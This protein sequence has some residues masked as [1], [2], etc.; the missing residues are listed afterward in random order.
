M[1][2]IYVILLW[3]FF[4]L[5]PAEGIGGDKQLKPENDPLLKA[6]QI[7]IKRAKEGL[8]LPEQPTPYFISFWIQ[9]RATASVS[10]KYGAI[11]H[12]HPDFHPYRTAGV[13]VRVGD[14]KLDNTNLPFSTRFSPESIEDMLGEGD[15][16]LSQV[17]IEGDGASLR[18]TLWLMSDTA[19]KG[20]VGDYQK[21]KVLQ[22][23]SVDNDKEQKPDDFS[24]HAPIVF[25]GPI[26]EISFDQEMWKDIVRK[27]TSHL[28]S[29]K[30]IMEPYMEVRADIIV[31]YYVNTEGAI[32][33]TSEVFYTVDIHAWTRAVD[34]AK[35]D[36]FRYFFVRD[37]KELQDTKNFIA[38]AES[39][40]DELTKLREAEEFKPYTGPAILGPDVAGVFFH[41][42]LGHRLEGERQRMPE[43]GQ[44]FKGK[45][46][47]GI[48]PEFLSII[49]DPT[50]DRLNGRTLTGYYAYDDEGVA[51]QKVVLVE[52]GILKNYLLSRTPIN[53]FNQ[54]N[55]HG[56]SQG[57]W[58]LTSFG[59]AVG[60]MAN[61]IVDSEKKFQ[62]QKLKTMLI[63]E[64][65]KQGKPYGLII[66][67]I[68][69][70]ETNT[71][72]SRGERG[73]NFQAFKATPILV[74]AIDVKTGEE[75]LVRGVELV[76]TPLV[77]LEKVI[78]TGDD[79][80]VFNGTCGAES[81][82][83][84]VSVVSPS[85]LTTQVE[86][87]R[88]VSK[89]KRPPILPSPFQQ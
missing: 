28:A 7:E 70:G 76:G 20:A 80:T 2:I 54:S 36:S 33:R 35:V 22:A 56:R 73:G 75:K 49:D 58:T 26:K 19:Y 45:V 89:S 55:G 38:E 86:V 44:T 66:R 77:S 13:Q 81:G 88:V 27:V 64:A 14:Y 11:T 32:L 25:V 40:A 74:Y 53:G 6:M 12:I 57:P 42:A 82:E 1:K 37:P 72:A 79:A 46:N 51:A 87:Q 63:E 39:L 30:E 23:T 47:E 62:W 65:K 3:I 9:E 69:A 24:R 67:R 83:V 60:R 78:A 16:N 17:P 85:I 50:M 21:K 31:N 5:I 84:T 15:W 8:K 29:K 10:G 48:L 59:H 61:L 34:G 68:R 4:I 41:E 52:R 71:Q 43:S 18:A